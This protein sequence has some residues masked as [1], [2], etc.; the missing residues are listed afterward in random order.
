MLPEGAQL[1][2]EAISRN[3]EITVTKANGKQIYIVA[4]GYLRRR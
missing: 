2:V 4:E 1:S 3:Y